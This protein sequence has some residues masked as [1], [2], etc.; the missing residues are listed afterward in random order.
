M[1]GYSNMAHR[2]GWRDR[3][4]GH[5]VSSEHLSAER[6][7]DIVN[8]LVPPSPEPAT[9]WLFLGSPQ[10]RPAPELAR[11]PGAVSEK[12]E[13]SVPVVTS[14]TVPAPADSVPAILKTGRHRRPASL[15]STVQAFASTSPRSEGPGRHRC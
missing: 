8:T 2:G 1:D 4:G 14:S 12:L 13:G 6:F 10:Q 3:R 11:R 15:R 7:A 9:K 5:A